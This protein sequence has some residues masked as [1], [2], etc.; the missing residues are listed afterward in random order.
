MQNDPGTDP[1]IILAVVETIR[2]S[3]HEVLGLNGAHGDVR[4]D[5]EINTTARRHREIIL[6]T[7]HPNAIGGANTSEERLSE[8]RDFA[9]PEIRSGSKNIGKCSSDQCAV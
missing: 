8:G 6:R 5:F 3:G 9:P 7:R 4:R 2:Q 1:K